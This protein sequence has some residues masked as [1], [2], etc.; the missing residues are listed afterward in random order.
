[1]EQAPLGVGGLHVC[2]K[3]GAGEALPQEPTRPL[4]YIAEFLT[5]V[6]VGIQTKAP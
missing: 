6:G 2:G 1:M 4:L 5:A 3:H